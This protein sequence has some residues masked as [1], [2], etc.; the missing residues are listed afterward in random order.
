[1]LR[2]LVLLLGFTFFTIVNAQDFLDTVTVDGYYVLIPGGMT[3]T[4][5]AGHLV[6][7]TT[8]KP[9]DG[10]ECVLDLTKA[11]VC[12]TLKANP[13]KDQ[14]GNT[15]TVTTYPPAPGIPSASGATWAGNG[16]GSSPWSSA[17]GSTYLR[18]KYGSKYS[19]DLNEPVAGNPSIDFT[20]Y[21]N[22]HDSCYTSF[23]LGGQPGCDKHFG[24]AIDGFCN[25]SS[26]KAD[27]TAFASDYEAAVKQYGKSAYDSDQ[28]QLSCAEWGDAMKTD[29]CNSK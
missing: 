3:S 29:G 8:K 21:C 16:C 26:D 6:N 7:S 28:A 11:Q 2:I 1:M 10:N 13:P 23:S 14:N 24:D 18:P 25:Q 12:N 9:C 22:T 27:C 15:C 17:W 20:G 5:F 4:V 19:G